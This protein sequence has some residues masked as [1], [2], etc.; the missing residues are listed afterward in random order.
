[1]GDDE[2]LRT[3]D[4]FTTPTDLAA[5]VARGAVQ[6]QPEPRH[7]R[8]AKKALR[9]TAKTSFVSRR[10]WLGKLAWNVVPMHGV[11]RIHDPAYEENSDQWRAQRCATDE[12]GG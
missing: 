9:H 1:M 8:R 6:P 12:G 2:T 10:P 7:A 3:S 11:L 4:G 5:P